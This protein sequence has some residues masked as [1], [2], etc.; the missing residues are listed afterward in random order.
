VDN[1]QQDKNLKIPQSFAARQQ[2]SKA[3]KLHL[4]FLVSPTEVIADTDGTVEGL[5]FEKNRLEIKPDGT[6]I[7][8]GTGEIEILDVGMALLAIGF[9]AGRIVGVPYHEKTGHYQ[10][11]Q[12]GR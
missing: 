6:A 5:V 11:R 1:S 7:T 4:H 10:R 9:A 12:P 3:K 2:G 8:H